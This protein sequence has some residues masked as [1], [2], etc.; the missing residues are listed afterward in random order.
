M[1]IN[2]MNCETIKKRK[3]EEKQL[4]LFKHNESPSF[5]IA[6]RCELILLVALLL[7]AFEQNN[8]IIQTISP[9]ILRS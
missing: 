1:Y 7:R 2:R 4:Q 3:E 6:Y 9:R 8:K 5:D